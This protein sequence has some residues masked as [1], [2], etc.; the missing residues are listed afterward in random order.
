MKKTLLTSMILGSLVGPMH[1]ALISGITLESGTTNPF[2]P[3]SMGPAK[4]INGEGLP[5]GIP[6]LS[7]AHTT[8]FTN[9]WWSSL[10]T[11][12]PQLTVNLNGAYNVDTIHIWNYNEAGQ[13]ARGTK[14]VEIYVSPD[15]DIANLVKL[16]TGGTGTH[17]NGLGNF[18]LPQ[19]SSLAD[20]VGFDLN[21]S[22]VTNASLLNNV[23]LIQF[24]PLD[25]YGGAFPDGV[26]LAE[27][28]FGAVPEPSAALLGGLSLLGLLRRRR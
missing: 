6:A 4:A 15:G 24:K 12:A 21:L 25:S 8:T 1:A 22:G 5:G 16:V 11:E 28:Q 13:N 18:L 19:A 23:S 9:G 20:Y 17:D 10:S 14:N 2:N 3:I 27:V 7:G 26:G